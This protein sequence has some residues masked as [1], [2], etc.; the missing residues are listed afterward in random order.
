MLT[1][2]TV[3]QLQ[4]FELSYLLDMLVRETSIYTKLISI[5]GITSH[6]RASKETIINI[7]AAIDRK[8]HLNKEMMG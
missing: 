8:V 6:S 4:A 3:Q 2:P 5:E 7:Q 1:T